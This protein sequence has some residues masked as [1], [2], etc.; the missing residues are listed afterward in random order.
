MG[1]GLTT[2]FRA[3]NR[4]TGRSSFSQDWNT[5]QRSNAA[6]HES[7]SAWMQRLLPGNSNHEMYRTLRSGVSGGMELGTLAL[8]GIGIAK[9]AYSLM[10][11][12]FSATRGPLTMQKIGRP[13]MPANALMQ[14]MRP[15]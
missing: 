10:Q 15:I 9:G 7:G 13:T 6:F 1:W 14:E 8:G 2:P 5:F 11:K 12:G 4:M 3:V